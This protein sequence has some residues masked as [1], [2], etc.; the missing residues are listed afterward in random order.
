MNPLLA[1][2]IAAVP[3]AVLGI[4]YMLRSGKEFVTAVVAADGG[5]VNQE[6]MQSLFMAAFGLAPFVFGLA[7][8]L[9]YQAL[10][11]PFFFTAAALGMAA[12]LSAA[13]FFTQGP[14][15]VEKIAMNFIVALDFGLLLPLL[16][17]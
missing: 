12:V 9:V 1:G 5:A 2:L 16:M 8:G 3:L 6:Q 4:A 10:S 7:A 11:T 14:L 15:K 13:V 17:R